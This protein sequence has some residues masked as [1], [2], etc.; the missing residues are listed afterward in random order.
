MSGKKKKLHAIRSPSGEV[1][2]RA[3]LGDFI[4]ED[5]HLY[6]I[7]R[8]TFTVY[9]G[10]EPA[11]VSNEVDSRLNEPGVEYN[12]A[13]RFEINLGILSGI[14]PDRPIL[15]VVASCGGDWEAG[16]QMFSAILSCPNPTTVLVT[17]WARSMT[18]IIP[19]AADKF[20]MRPPAKYMFHYGTYGFGGLVQEVATDFVELMKSREMMLNLYAARLKEQGKFSRWSKGRIRE[21][22][23]RQVEKKIDV[24]LYADEA[25][26][27][28]L[29]D[30]IFD[31]NHNTL[32]ALKKDEK[33]RKTMFEVLRVSTE[34]KIDILSPSLMP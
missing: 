6:R 30:D 5:V 4:P 19:L 2:S 25:K 23:T 33:R 18:S 20:V 15:I 34:V 32:R 9:V 12:M 17:K 16:M 29:V 31:G 14:D 3:L 21:M 28:G 7:N 10:G 24:W 11:I 26:Q 13:D 22:L 1:I 27:W 8:H